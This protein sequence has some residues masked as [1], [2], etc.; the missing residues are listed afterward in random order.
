MYS[1][2][3]LH[4]IFD[5]II[6]GVPTEGH[7]LTRIRSRTN[8]VNERV[9]WKKKR[10]DVTDQINAA[11]TYTLAP[12]M[13]YVIYEQVIY[14]KRTYSVYNVLPTYYFDPRAVTTF[15]QFRKYISSLTKVLRISSFAICMHSGQSQTIFTYTIFTYTSF[16]NRFVLIFIEIEVSVIEINK[17][18]LIQYIGINTVSERTSLVELSRW[19]IGE[20]WLK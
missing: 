17:K 9:V 6:R 18:M 11:N 19:R 16:T 8:V 2:Q 3:I 7:S 5:H 20:S 1:K 4:R 15:I 10:K 13:P 12:H 14:F